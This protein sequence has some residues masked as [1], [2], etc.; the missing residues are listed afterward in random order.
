MLLQHL[1]L[2]HWDPVP[3]AGAEVLLLR[4][5]L[6]QEGPS[7]EVWDKPWK[8]KEH[9]AVLPAVSYTKPVILTL[10]PCVPL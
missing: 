9:V 8:V 3:T 2:R 6:V 5:P 7:L 1:G 10:T 4:L